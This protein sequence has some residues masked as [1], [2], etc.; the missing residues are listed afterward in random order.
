[1]NTTLATP[2]A[3]PVTR[4]TTIAG[5]VA[6]ADQLSKLLAVSTLEVH[7][8]IPVIAPVFELMLTYNEGAAFSMLGDA[9]GWQ[10]WLFITLAS[11]VSVL[12]VIWLSRLKA[13][14]RATGWALTLILG[15]AV[16]NLV[17]RV[18]RDGRVVDFI[19]LHY[20]RFHWPAFNLA[21]TAICVGAAI[22]VL[23]SF[24]KEHRGG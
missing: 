7:R 16:G 24:R 3:W 22:L 8:P 11:V 5:V 17:D 14:E 20:E 19:Y 9:S 6:V 18:F 15:G 1:M 23:T 10:R 12:L 13:G 4:W 21:D 2:G